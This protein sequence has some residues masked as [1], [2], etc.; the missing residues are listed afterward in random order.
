MV[1]RKSVDFAKGFFK[2]VLKIYLFLVISNKEEIF[3]ANNCFGHFLIL[4]FSK[5]TP[6]KT[7]QTR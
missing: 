3:G 5:Q 2:K 6:P 1:L 4:G 7:L